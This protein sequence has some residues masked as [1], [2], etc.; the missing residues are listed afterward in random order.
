V[1]LSAVDGSSEVDVLDERHGFHCFGYRTKLWLAGLGMSTRSMF[2]SKHKQTRISTGIPYVS[3]VEMIE[4]YTHLR[5]LIVHVSVYLCFCTSLCMYPGIFIRHVAC[6]PTGLSQ[7]TATCM[8]LLIVLA[9][10]YGP[11]SWFEHED[12]FILAH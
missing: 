4:R 6:M 1:Q 3:Q 5:D 10:S 12:R 2:C 11:A 9:A 8:T 7:S